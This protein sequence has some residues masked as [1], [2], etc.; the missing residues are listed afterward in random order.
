MS[1]NAHINPPF[2][3]P[4]EVLK[5]VLKPL[6]EAWE[7]VADFGKFTQKNGENSSFWTFS[8][9]GAISSVLLYVGIYS[10]QQKS[11]KIKIAPPP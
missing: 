11:A 7:S 9:F 5:T 1:K 8:V 10:E 2:K 4:P 3:P 6:G